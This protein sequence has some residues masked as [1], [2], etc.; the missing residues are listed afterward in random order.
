MC[1]PRGTPEQ[2]HS[3]EKSPQTPSCKTPRYF[4]E[5]WPWPTTAI[6][7]RQGRHTITI[8]SNCQSLEDEWKIEFRIWMAGVGWSHCVT[9]KNVRSVEV[10]DYLQEGREPQRKCFDPVAYSLKSSSVLLKALICVVT[11]LSLWTTKGHGQLLVQP[12]SSHK[13]GDPGQ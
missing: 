3:L 13:N 12:G 1:P 6:A 2:L 5:V 8:A 10:V 7:V 11:L 9:G 4:I